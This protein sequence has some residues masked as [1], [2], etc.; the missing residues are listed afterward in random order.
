MCESSWRLRWPS[1][2]RLPELSHLPHETRQQ[3]VKQVWP[4]GEPPSPNKNQYS[5]QELCMVLSLLCVST[6][7]LLGVLT[8]SQPNSVLLLIIATVLAMGVISLACFAA[9]YSAAEARLKQFEIDLRWYCKEGTLR[10]CPSCGYDLYGSASDTCPECGTPIQVP[11]ISIPE[12]IP[13]NSPGRSRFAWF[14]SL[15]DNNPAFDK[16]PLPIRARLVQRYDKN[17]ASYKPPKIV[18]R[19]TWLLIGLAI[20]FV[21]SSPKFE[22]L[23]DDFTKNSTAIA[24]YLAIFTP[25]SILYLIL[26]PKLQPRETP[27]SRWL[28]ASFSDG[29]I[30]PCI[31][32]GCDITDKQECSC[33]KCG[34]TVYR[35]DV[36]Q[37]PKQLKQD[38]S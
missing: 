22:M 28:K 5:L 24:V 37:G 25:V 27:F 14:D 10:Q 36:D 4:D 9:F 35:L 30:T 20:L 19:L 8:L 12:D 18:K 15:L 1:I 34:D 2:S 26:F 23:I 29:V 6:A 32:C 7:P 16:L 3:L 11:C 38:Q 33:P 13:E 17:E 21:I 31:Q